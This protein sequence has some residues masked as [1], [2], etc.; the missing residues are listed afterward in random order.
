MV[1]TPILSAGSK[2][3]DSVTGSQR[4][5]TLLELLVVIT[6]VTLAV[7]V[8]GANYQRGLPGAQLQTQTRQLIAQLRYARGQ[9]LAESA[10]LALAAGEQ[11][12]SY[13]ILPGNEYTELPPGFSV[14]IQATDIE[15]PGYS[16]FSPLAE[17]AGE[18]EFR[19]EIV[20]REPSPG[21]DAL[22]ASQPR[23]SAGG[24]QQIQFFPDGSSS[25][26]EVSLQSP[27]GG[28]RITVNW[29]TGEVA[30]APDA[31]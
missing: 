25:G 3:R 26:G 19:T 31:P 6:L 12:R 15:V 20:I 2:G 29:L 1:K 14:D 5:F 30:L 22:V 9:A 11:G 17:E 4:G 16:G 10:V 27:A 21:A 23:A 8:V 24:G 18:E 13:Q 28:S 7:A